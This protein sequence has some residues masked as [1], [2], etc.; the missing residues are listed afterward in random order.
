MYS[1]KSKIKSVGVARSG[2]MGSGIAEVAATAGFDVVVR[3]RSQHSADAAVGRLAKSLGKQVD[4]GKLSMED[5]DAALARVRATTELGDLE[6]CDL[7]G[8]SVVEDASP[9]WWHRG[10]GPV[11]RRRPGR[12]RDRARRTVS[13]PTSSVPVRELAGT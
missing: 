7:V 2:M 9:R 10:C 12:S 4:S 6:A 8:E 13:E 3:G 11:W 1:I 5:S